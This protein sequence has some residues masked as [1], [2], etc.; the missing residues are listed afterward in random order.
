MNDATFIETAYEW[1]PEEA[2]A[3]AEAGAIL[4]RMLPVLRERISM[5]GE[6]T[7][8]VTDGELTFAFTEPSPS[9][10]LLKWKKDTEV[11]AALPRLLKVIELIEA[12]CS[13]YP[14]P[15]EGK[16]VLWN[17]VEEVGRGE[18]LWP[19]RVALT[20][21]ERSPDPFSALSILGTAESIKRI[22]KACDTIKSA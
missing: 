16:A 19:L 9:T 15:A 5:L 18:V 3:R 4:S 13:E 1:L 7:K 8:E 20:G 10:E 22:K 17:Y 21:K 2:R 11:S 14:T 6:I 12:N